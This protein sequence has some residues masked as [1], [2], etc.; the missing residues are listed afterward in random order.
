MKLEM[1]MKLQMKLAPQLIQSLKL[2][3]MP[4]LKLEQMV[5]H[6][7]STNPLLEEAPDEPDEATSASTDGEGD[8]TDPQLDK[9][10]WEDYLRDDGEFYARR[11]REPEE[12]RL[13]RTPAGEKNLYEHLMDQ[14]HLSRLGQQ[15]VGIGEYIIGNIDENGYLVCSTDEIASAMDASPEQVSKVLSHIQSFDP[16]GVGARDLRESLLIQ[17]KEKGFEESLAYRIVR[18]HLSDLE[19]KSFT[20]LSRTVGVGFEEIQTAMD[21]IKTLNPRPAMGRFTRAATPVVP[22]LVVEKIGDEFVIFHND[23]NVPRL[24]I[25]SAYRALLKKGSLRSGETKTYLEGKL[26]KARW[27]LNAINQRRSTMIKVMEKIVEEQKEFFDHG[28]SHL[29]PLTMEAIAERVG[30]NV[31]T[32]SRVSN[33]KYVQTPQGIFEIKYFFNTGVPRENGENLSKRNVKQFISDFIR[34]ENPSAPLSDQQIYELLKKQGINIARRTVSKYREEL[35]ILP[36]RFRKRMVKAEIKGP[37]TESVNL[38]SGD[39]T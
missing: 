37:Q 36:A 30:M 28:P 38:P 4:I 14:L 10:N 23:K 13:E 34:K 26:E 5:R 8:Q 16:T 22:D 35:K 20:Q 15:E 12:E 21:F 2:L 39:S 7:L 25:S 29:K 9:I 3:Q 32:I 18:D 33:G 19:K 17:L 11:E 27:L 6:E 1:H 31:A 24:R